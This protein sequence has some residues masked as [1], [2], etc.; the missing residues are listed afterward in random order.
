MTKSGVTTCSG[1]TKD[2][3]QFKAS[4]PP[5]TR[6]FA[7]LLDKIDRALQLER[8]SVLAVTTHE[9]NA[10]IATYSAW[11]E[12]VSTCSECYF[13]DGESEETAALKHCALLFQLIIETPSPSDAMQLQ[14]SLLEQSALFAVRTVD[15]QGLVARATDQIGEIVTLKRAQSKA[16]SYLN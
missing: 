16:I 11:L 14:A 13:M 12:I 2:L 5:I 7:T 6:A 8:A 1:A 10:R 15:L 3:P 4:P 9:D